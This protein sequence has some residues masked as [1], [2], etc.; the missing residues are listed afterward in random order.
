MG[1]KPIVMDPERLSKPCQ[2]VMHINDV[3]AVIQNLKDTARTEPT[4]AG[5]ASN[6][7][8][9]ECRVFVV[10]IRGKFLH[11]INPS[12]TPKGPAMVSFKESCLSFP[13]MTTETRRH[14]QITAYGHKKGKSMI[15]SGIEAIAFQHELDHLNGICI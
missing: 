13:G 8:G 7:I 14:A 6:Q 15:L 12:F 4:C 1:A 5:L 2:E 10:K 9:Y 3:Q 11:F